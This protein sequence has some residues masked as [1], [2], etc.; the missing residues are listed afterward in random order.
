MSN[1]LKTQNSPYLLQHAD[2]PVD[3]F[4][5]CEEAFEKALREDKPVFVSIGYS[6]CHWCHVMARESF[7]D[8]KTAELLNKYFIAVKVDREERPDLDSVYLAVCQAFTGSGGWPMSIFMTAQQKPFFAGTYF[9]PHARYGMP[10]F[11]DL[12]LLI[13]KKWRT[14]RGRLLESADQIFAALT[15]EAAHKS[16]LSH[17]I[18]D[19]LVPDAVR[20]FSE[21]FDR[22]NGGFGPAPK[23]PLGHHLIFL[24][25]YARL[26][27]QSEPL[28]QALVTLKQM[29]KGGI[30][31]QIGYGFSRYSTDARFLVPHFEKML[32]DNALL[33][34]A[35]TVAFRAA[36]EYALLKTAEQTADYVLRE[37]TGDNGA[38]FSAQDADS[39][40]EEGK[41]Y[42]FSQEEVCRVL[43]NEKG[44]AYCRH[45]GITKQG[46]FEGKNIPNLLHTDHADD[47]AVDFEEERKR[48]YD[49]RKTR[50][51]LHLD[52][53]VLTS[54]NAL[55][56]CALSF[57]YRASGQ[58]R[59]LEAAKKA[60]AWISRHLT[61]GNA[62]YT[63]CRGNA[64]FAYGFLDDYAYEILA[65]L[66]LYG[67]DGA[68]EDLERAKALCLEA[69]EQFGD[70]KGGYFLNGIKN[71]TLMIRPKE[72]YDGALPSGNSV[73]AYCLVRL[74]QLTQDER[75]RSAAEQQLAFLSQEAAHDPS[76]YSVF[77]T[78]LLYD[79]NPPEKITVVLAKEDTVGEI[80]PKLP[81]YADLMVLEQETGSYRLLNGKTTYYVCKN[82][83]CQ[84]PVNQLLSSTTA[85]G[86]SRR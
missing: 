56:I 15:A 37:M 40:G 11:S 35:Y 13:D 81:L 86:E 39:D 49:Y 70:A 58:A 31:D 29:R 43:G 45:F 21:R 77:L 65:L 84:P 76:G 52:D 57:L 66:A 79:Q 69:M 10:G 74:S 12:L 71:E 83:S 18:I 3:W 30:F 59:Y 55:M 36:G 17:D 6:T 60:Q 64:L 8:T 24:M 7:E 61:D 51:T 9:P 48:L 78:A 22:V 72:T 44:M 5:W 23:F 82:N 2:N 1:R 46:N 26:Y 4:P 27:D 47:L 32:Y 50:T 33:I 62:L 28:R 85:A 67:A 38:F 41:Y 20:I 16:M 14:E 53:K 63:G 42:V 73:L 34:L 75:F 68:C 19:G 25:L 80:L 54:W